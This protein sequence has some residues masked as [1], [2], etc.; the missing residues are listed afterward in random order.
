MA[1]Q[2][3]YQ[4]DEEVETGPVAFQQLAALL[5][6]GVL[7]PDSLVKDAKSQDWQRV[8]DVPGLL[9]QAKR[10]MQPA[11]TSPPPPR[12]STPKSRRETVSDAAISSEPPASSSW[13][14]YLG[15]VLVALFLAG[16]IWWI[17]PRTPERFPESKPVTLQFETPS[18]LAQM[19][20][21]SRRDPQR[22]LATFGPPQ[23]VPGLESVAWA[24]T[25]T[26]TPDLLT[27]V[28]VS[29][30]GN[31]T[32]DDLF[33]AERP[34]IDQ[35]FATPIKLTAC[36]GPKREMFPSLSTDGL[37]LLFA[38][39]AGP[40]RIMLAQRTQRGVPFEAAQQL[41]IEKLDPA[42]SQLDNPQWL[43]AEEI[44]LTASSGDNQRRAH[45][46]AR[47]SPA[48]NA[49]VIMSQLGYANPWPR[50]VLFPQ[51]RRAYFANDE[52][53]GLMM[54]VPRTAQFTTPELWLTNEQ[55]GPDM[56]KFDDKPW[57]SPTE[58]TLVFC[59]PGHETP[60]S[61]DRYVWM[62][63]LD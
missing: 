3:F 57:I 62:L 37:K 53:L 41:P 27:L 55:L 56:P 35:P 21:R 59:S 19:A 51:R 36:S 2:W 18:R 31:D 58:D 38:E 47:R 20:P 6:D 1:T 30:G 23:R 11:L 49:F 52:G 54:Q 4:S 8:E 32:L 45:F 5:N 9:S 61:R 25:P 60:E 12:A 15:I 39:D 50:Y 10:L 29:A 42:F 63:K 26:L 34:A 16:E 17:W 43:S 28:Y 7:H 48:G 40:T 24:K 22:A 13:G 33:L 14:A 44:S 46:L